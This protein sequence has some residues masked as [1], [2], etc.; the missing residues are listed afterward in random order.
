VPR[1]KLFFT[2][3]KE[4]KFVAQVVHPDEN[5]KEVSTSLRVQTL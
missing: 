3:E 1:D 5:K 4:N 2:L